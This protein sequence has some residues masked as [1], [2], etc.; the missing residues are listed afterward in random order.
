MLQAATALS[1]NNSSL[2]GAGSPASPEI[3]NHCPWLWIPDSLAS[4]GFRNDELSGLMSAVIAARYPAIA[5]GFG[6]VP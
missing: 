1:R 2:R 3:H 6:L 4:L 5:L